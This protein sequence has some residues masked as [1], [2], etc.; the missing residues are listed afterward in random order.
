MAVEWIGKERVDFH[1][2][3]MVKDMFLLR[4]RRKVEDVNINKSERVKYFGRHFQLA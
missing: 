2:K 3:D 1:I 4:R